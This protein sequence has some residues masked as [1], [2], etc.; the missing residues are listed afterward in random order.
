VTSV[1]EEKEFNT[2]VN[3]TEDEFVK[4]MET[5]GLAPPKKIGMSEVIS[6]PEKF[7]L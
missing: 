4:I 1:E 5:L 6:L 7:H 2:R 3:H